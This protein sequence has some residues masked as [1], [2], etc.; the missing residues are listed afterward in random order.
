[1]SD[2]LWNTL[3]TLCHLIAVT[4]IPI[5]YRSK[6]ELER[7]NNL[8]KVT[9]LVNGEIGIWTKETYTQDIILSPYTESMQEGMIEHSTV[10]WET[11]IL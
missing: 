11:I 8:L 9:Q 6:L 1:M 4:I 2:I 3:Q 5:V 10:A 7:L